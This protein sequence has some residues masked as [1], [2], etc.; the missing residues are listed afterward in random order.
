[1]FMSCGFQRA[2]SEER[3]RA[4]KKDGEKSRYN[5]ERNHNFVFNLRR[6]IYTPM[7]IQQFN[8]LHSI[9]Q[10]AIHTHV[11]FGY[12]RQQNMHAHVQVE[13]NGGVVFA[14]VWLGLAWLGSAR[15]C[16]H[17]D[18]DDNCMRVCVFESIKSIH[19]WCAVTAS[20][21]FNR[22]DTNNRK[23]HEETQRPRPRPIYTFELW[24]KW[25]VPPN[26]IRQLNFV[27]KLIFVCFVPTKDGI[28]KINTIFSV[29]VFSLIECL[30]LCLCVCF[31]Q[32][33]NKNE[34]KWGFSQIKTKNIVIINEKKKN[35]RFY[36]LFVTEKSRPL[37]LS[38]GWVIFD[39]EKKSKSLHSE[40]SK[41]FVCLK[42]AFE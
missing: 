28:Y 7:C 15:S 32:F 3:Q 4:R 14:L 22:F 5:E 24:S 12:T 13:K 37:S 25:N 41:R 27:R 1:M 31:S 34:I 6:M 35:I 23:D 8:I 10:L 40:E 38:L 21:P 36:F 11:T 26:F 16:L 18:G 33:N 30:R 39:V 20:V 42:V 9:V 17:T 2:S 19:W 29:C